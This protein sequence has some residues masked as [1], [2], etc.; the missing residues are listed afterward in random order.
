[1]GVVERVE[2]IPSRDLLMDAER[3]CGADGALEACCEL[4]DEE[5]YPAKNLDSVRLRGWLATS[6][7]TRRW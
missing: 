6:A 1:M 3:V 2:R 4:V 7:R 5:K